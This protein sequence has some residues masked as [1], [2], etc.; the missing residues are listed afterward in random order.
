MVSTISGQSATPGEV[1]GAAVNAAFTH[2]V[3]IAVD[4]S[5][6]VYVTD[7]GTNAGFIREISA[8]GLVSTLAGSNQG[9][10]GNID[11]TGSSPRSVHRL[12]SR[13]TRAAIFM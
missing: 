12:E 6:N 5:N 11:A 2:P 3:G 7:G 8:G 13:S 1:D 4:R 9:L 10:T